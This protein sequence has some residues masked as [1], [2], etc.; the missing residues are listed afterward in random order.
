VEPVTPGPGERGGAP[1]R[2]GYV[3][4]TTAGG[5][6]PHVAMLAQGCVA[7]GMAVRVFGP[8]ETGRRYFAGPEQGGAP[9]P[10]QGV[11][12]GPEHG[13]ARGPE[14]GGAPRPEHG[15]ARGPEHGGARGPEHGGA[16]GPEQGGAPG[17]GGRPG[18]AAVEMSDRPRPAHD[19]AAV[20]RLRRLLRDWAPDVVHAHGLRAG[21]FAALARA[22][23]PGALVVTVHNA[24]PAA[25]SGRL[26]HAALE[27]LVARRSDAVTWVSGDI[28]AR[29]RRAGARDGGRAVVAAPGFAPPGAAQVAAA[30]AELGAAGRPAVL[31]AGRLTEQK[32]FGVLIDAAARW[33][34][35]DPAPLLAIAGDGPLAAALAG[36]AQAARVPVRF[37]G[38]RADV[39]ALMA[40]ADVV[41]VPSLW[42]GQPLVVQEALRAGRPLVASRAG[43]IPDLTG[44]DGALLVPAG[45]AGALAEAVLSV[46]DDRAVAARLGA[47][48]TQRGA[49]LP[50]AEHAVDSAIALYRRVISVA[51]GQTEQKIRNRS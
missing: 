30:R 26:V 32:G 29:A 18:F 34:D 36:Q 40:A 33:Q 44:E 49:A 8:A 3:L 42:E 21:A 6:G 10:E 14:H 19:L 9:R 11:A 41:V 45:D 43:G 2:I 23:L 38:R 35:R 24:P 51:S 12:P 25:G 5:T 15:G 20:R 1:L 48:A 46:L 7:R 16:R 27:R 13:G 31:A 50:S 17:P 39:P 22:G 37:L 4:G 47:A 28:A